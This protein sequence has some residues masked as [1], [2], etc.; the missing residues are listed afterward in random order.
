MDFQGE[1][2]MFPYFQP[3]L[4]AD[5]GKIYSYEALGRYSRADGQVCSLGSFFEDS[6]TTNEDAL[7]VDR[8]IRRLAMEQFVRESNSELLFINIRLQ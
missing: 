1:E 2:Q 5:T 6:T 3:I 4:S 7:R 8:K